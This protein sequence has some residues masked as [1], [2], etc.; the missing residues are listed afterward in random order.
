MRL[1]L[2]L[3][4]VLFAFPATAG[5]TASVGE[6]LDRYEMPSTD[7]SR[8]K[9]AMRSAFDPSCECFLF[10]RG[11]ET[12]EGKRGKVVKV[13][14]PKNDGD[15]RVIIELIRRGIWVPLQT[16]NQGY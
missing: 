6:W 13:R 8:F 14:R 9:A 7:R 10:L 4:L 1:S 12:T 11:K 5:E 15:R 2:I 16:K 3:A